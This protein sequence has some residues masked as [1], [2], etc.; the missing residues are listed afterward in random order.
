MHRASYSAG[1]RYWSV[2]R[3][4]EKNSPVAPA[5]R[6]AQLNSIVMSVT[7]S[8]ADRTFPG[9]IECPTGTGSVPRGS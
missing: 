9:R 3:N 2:A 1:V 8:N 4:E 7:S 6:K 5:S